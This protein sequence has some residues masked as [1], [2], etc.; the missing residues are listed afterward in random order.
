[1]SKEVFKRIEFLMNSCKAEKRDID[2]A[3]R[4]R[5]DARNGARLGPSSS[6]DRYQNYD[7]ERVM[8]GVIK[9]TTSQ[10]IEMERKA[11]RRMEEERGRMNLNLR[12][13]SNSN[14]SAFSNVKSK[15]NEIHSSIFFK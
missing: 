11:V 13:R 12:G 1:M 15:S 9:N 6:N 4:R 14:S 10:V 8:S 3:K 2:I 5:V 7:R